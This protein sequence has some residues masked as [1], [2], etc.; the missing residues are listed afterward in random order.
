[1]SNRDSGQV[2]LVT[3]GG[4]GVGRRVCLTLAERGYAIAVNDLFES[5]AAHVA[6][7]IKSLGGEAVG[8]AADVTDL[9]TVAEM[10]SEARRRLGPISALI[11]NAG[12]IIERRTGEVG[13][14]YF[15]ESNP[16]DWR[17]I[18]DL[19]IVGAMNCV[20]AVAPQMLDAGRGRIVS[21][22][23][24]AG[25][26][27]EARMAVYSGAKA[28]I[29]GFTKALARELGPKGIT[30][31]VIAL[32]AVSH[33]SPM[34]DFLAEDATPENNETLRKVL[35][36]YPLG[37]GLGRLARPADAAG[38]IAFLCS[39]DAVYI[40]GQCVAVNGGFAMV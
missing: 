34:A 31:N 21:V 20:H 15:H 30:A 24:E 2:A 9:G 36:M 40:T 23:S 35:R 28:A 22:I 33:E 26:V 6:Q 10:V 12:I 16:A 11:N 25:R 19:N 39:D 1:M 29:F 32:A 37:Q 7:E 4:Q 18:L 8:I 17:K 38:A 13:L 3:G 5:R 14:P 27:G